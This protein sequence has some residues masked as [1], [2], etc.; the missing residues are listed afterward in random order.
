M[1][2]LEDL[3]RI[4]HERVDLDRR[5][6]LHVSPGVVLEE[7]TAVGRLA[8]SGSATVALGDPERAVASS[9]TTDDGGAA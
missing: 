7:A 1:A 3:N 5:V 4:A 9:N 6:G 8:V 2:R